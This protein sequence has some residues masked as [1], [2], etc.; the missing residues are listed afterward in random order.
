[1]DATHTRNLAGRALAAALAA[2]AFAFAAPA[3]N[4]PV[5][6]GQDHDTAVAA[7]KAKG[8][9]FQEAPSGEGRRITY[10]AG[11]ENVALEF[12]PWPKDAN[13]P[14][15]AW[16]PGSTAPKQLTLTRIEDTAPSSEARRAWVNSLAKEGH[17]WAYLPAAEDGARPAADRSKYPVA[18]GLTWRTPP[19]KL[20]FQAARPMGAPPGAE[21]TELVIEL[22]RPRRS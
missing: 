16:D 10:S 5:S 15:S 22:T 21:A 20:V 18:A 4:L 9:A 7:L 2:A 14:A 19:A 17:G 1:M 12:S 6:V 11:N 3:Q 13:A 8:I